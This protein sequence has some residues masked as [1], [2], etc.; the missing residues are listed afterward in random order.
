LK[1]IGFGPDGRTSTSKITRSGST[2]EIRCQSGELLPLVLRRVRGNAPPPTRKMSTT[3]NLPRHFLH[4]VKQNTCI[5]TNERRST[6][7]LRYFG[8]RLMWLR[9]EGYT[10]RSGV[11][12]KDAFSGAVISSEIL[13]HFLQRNQSPSSFCSGCSVTVKLLPLWSL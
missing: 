5:R 7:A 2:C 10:A 11:L 4:F 6:V 9:D 1:E 12:D 8:R 13:P 3:C